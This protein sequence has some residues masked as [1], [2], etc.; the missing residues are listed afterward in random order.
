LF[1]TSP[2]SRSGTYGIS[3]AIASFDAQIGADTRL[4][5]TDALRRRDNFAKH[6]VFA[7]STDSPV[8]LKRHEVL[9]T[10]GFLFSFSGEPEHL[11]L[12]GGETGTESEHSLCAA[13]KNC[14]AEKLASS[15]LYSRREILCGTD[16]S[17]PPRSATESR[18]CGFSARIGEIDRACGFI[19]VKR[20]TGEKHFPAFRA[21]D[22]TKVSV[23][24]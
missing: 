15:G 20:G 8:S 6:P 23:G 18:L 22:A 13:D 2:L 5:G 11:C 16:S 10:R 24:K 3:S 9:H 21:Q 17:N 12:R 7:K 14:R 19:C 4:G 1:F